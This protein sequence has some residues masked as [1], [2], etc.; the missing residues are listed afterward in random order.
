MITER[1]YHRALDTVTSFHK[2]EYDR[3]SVA[4]FEKFERHEQSSGFNP[5]DEYGNE[6]YIING[7][8]AYKLFKPT[9]YKFG[10]RPDTKASEKF[11][12]KL[13]DPGVYIMSTRKTN[14]SFFTDSAK[15]VEDL[16]AKFL[17][18]IKRLQF[19]ADFNLISKKSLHKELRKHM[20]PVREKKETLMLKEV[21]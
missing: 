12:K 18:N 19:I 4:I 21:A 10:L 16:H 11:H 13:F 7:I 8:I 2:Q 9:E 17:T 3:L 15:E 20:K 14:Y 5:R 6:R 1:E